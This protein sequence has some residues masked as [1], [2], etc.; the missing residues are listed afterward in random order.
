MQRSQS[1]SLLETTAGSSSANVE[2]S[3]GNYGHWQ[4]FRGSSSLLKSAMDQEEEEEE[5]EVNY[6]DEEQALMQLKKI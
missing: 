6:E 4:P 1:N 5:I 3:P 2:P